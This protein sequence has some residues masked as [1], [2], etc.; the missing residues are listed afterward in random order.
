M[1][2]RESF[3]FEDDPLNEELVPS[4]DNNDGN[5][6]ENSEQEI[7]SSALETDDP[8]AGASRESS[9]AASSLSQKP[10]NDS[11]SESPLFPGLH[12]KG[13]PIT[14]FPV[15]G[16]DSANPGIGG[17][18]DSTDAASERTSIE[19]DPTKDFWENENPRQPPNTQPPWRE[20]TETDPLLGGGSGNPQGRPGSR[21]L[22]ELEERDRLRA[23]FDRHYDTFADY[24]AQFEDSVSVSSFVYVAGHGFT[25]P[26]GYLAWQQTGEWPAEPLSPARKQ[27]SQR[28]KCLFWCGLPFVLALL[29]LMVAVLIMVFAGLKLPWVSED[30]PFNFA[31]RSA[32]THVATHEPLL[33]PDPSSSSLSVQI[34]FRLPDPSFSPS[35]SQTVDQPPPPLTVPPSSPS[36]EASE[37]PGHHTTTKWRQMYYVYIPDQ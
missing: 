21:P 32:S 9:Q 16:G 12:A 7:S 28:R 25:D 18:K 14:D 27:R 37:E 8:D 15:D 24:A 13:N 23:E 29:L 4:K 2:R 22:N 34:P 36:D 26:D 33:L 3:G 10:S 6:I 20:P 35:S 5:S 31:R 30:S 1:A 11:G 17:S 19:I